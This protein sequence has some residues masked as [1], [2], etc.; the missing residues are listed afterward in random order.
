MK[1]TDSYDLI[2]I[3]GGSGGYAAAKTALK[4]N[5]K[6][7]VVDSA[8]ELGGLC[9]L[10]GCMPTKTLIE[11]ANRLRAIQEADE[12]G[13]QVSPG[14]LD[15]Q[16]LRDRK[17]RLIDGFKEYRVKGLTNG[18]FDL[19]RGPGKFTGPHQ[20]SVKTSDGEV[21]LE[22]K[23]FVIA[24]GSVGAVPEIDGLEDTPF[25]TSD[26]IVELPSVPK[27]VIV[28]GTGAIGMETAF[29]MQGLGSK[30]T[31][32]SR[33]RPLLSCTEPEMS[34]AMMKRCDDLHIEVVFEHDT[35]KVSHQEETFSVH[36]KDKNTGEEK[37]LEAEQLVMATGRAARIEGLDLAQAGFTEEGGCLKIDEHCQTMVSHIFAAG[38]CASPLEVV[39]LAVLQGEAAGANV[40]TFLKD[41][42]L[43]FEKSWDE[44]LKMLGVFTDPE[45]VQ[46]GM[47]EHEAKEE[48]YEAVSATYRYDDQ[49]K[50]EIVGEKHGLVKLVA[51]KK[52]GRIL[53][54][55]GMGPHVIDYS[56]TI[57][58]ALH[59]NLTVE[60]F[61]SI[62][63]YHPT[64][65]EI[66]A[67][68]AED[69]LEEMS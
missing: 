12:F 52:S 20:I 50:G 65:G 31:I 38:D 68:V 53:G 29:L 43:E 36:L 4:K 56:H 67:Y 6:V 23:A 30:V 1:Q 16:A 21:S 5:L 3:G 15:I 57:M 40:A 25:W 46:V 14:T 44:R 60:E 17:D 2:V 42:K 58:V 45:L 35:E 32:L 27:D 48:G 19:Y 8:E 54:C 10:R 28:V 41:P 22:S 62:P 64:L 39:H 24:T 61:V 18:D 63:S 66:W 69:L 37:V 49:G 7:A 55:S 9:I 11:T 59:Q 13:I 51:D 26:D 47:T 34:E 33:S